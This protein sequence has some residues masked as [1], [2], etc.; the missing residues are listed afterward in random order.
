MANEHPFQHL[1][2]TLGRTPLAHAE[3]VNRQAYEVLSDILDVP[4]EKSGRCILLRAPRAGHGKTHLL[5]R[6]QHQMGGTHEFIPL[7]ASFGCRIDAASV[8]DDT[9]RC[10]V[11]QLPASGGLCVLDL[12]TRRLFASALQP[13]VGSGEVPCQ[14]REGALAA[15][16]LRPVET[17]D[18]HHPN[19]VTAHWARENFEVLGQRLSLELAQRADLP[20]REVAFWVDALFRFAASPLDNSNRV[21]ILADTVHEG[22]GGEME[23]LEALLGLVTQ[24]MRVV[25]V[26]DDLEGFSSDETAA[27]RFGAFLGGLRQTVDRLDVILSLNLDIW[28][29][30]FVPRLSGGLADRLSEIVVELEPLTETEMAALLDSRV[31]GLGGKVL[32]RIDIGSSG[33]HARGLIR[34]AG[35]AWL[36]ATAMDTA[37]AVVPAPAVVSPPVSAPISQVVAAAPPVFAPPE[38]VSP[39]APEAPPVLEEMTAPVMAPAAVFTPVA[40]I[41]ADAT[42][43]WPT[44]E[45]SPPPTVQIEATDPPIEIPQPAAQAGLFFQPE[46]APTWNPP[47]PVSDPVALQPP[48]DSPFQV[49][50]PSMVPEPVEFQPA[51]HEPSMFEPVTEPVALQPPFVP[52][53]VDFQPAAQ[54][55]YAF[56]PPP[57]EPDFQAQAASPFAPSPPTFVSAEP[58]PPAA[59]S[60][61]PFQP[62]S[63]SPFQ[64]APHEPYTFNP[65]PTQPELQPQADSPFQAVPSPFIAAPFA[66]QEPIYPQETFQPASESPF[67]A[68]APLFTPA[69]S[70]TA[71]QPA[72]EPDPVEPFVPLEATPP[73]S[74]ADTD[75]V[76][77]L[78]RQFR[79]RYGRGSL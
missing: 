61:G 24:L 34:A 58:E 35:M 1:F 45:F 7:H 78:L 76:D 51:V 33:S 56:N 48:V 32:E 68:A 60:Q 17:F 59:F 29:S 31:P 64:P 44:P 73:P 66:P 71:F 77:D 69:E 67:Q 43:S 42:P 62:V 26:A 46:T 16:R 50:P 53:P 20:V 38:A 19:A 4:V 14:D 27:L 5:S 55:P 72:P 11:K 22:T 6:I 12:V 25:L 54:E 8:I 57:S 23:R 49:P 30:A 65:P 36:K 70:A 13:L 39:P 28:E 74:A 3:S 10:L 37:P 79:E 18:F 41:V 63:E 52:G 2:E 47:A 21:R 15:L 9:L 40:P 75:R